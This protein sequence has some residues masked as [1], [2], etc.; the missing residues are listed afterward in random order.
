MAA[1][2]HSN[3]WLNGNYLGVVSIKSSEILL[4]VIS[5]VRTSDCY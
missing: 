5:S 3:F 2:D 1:F 4:V